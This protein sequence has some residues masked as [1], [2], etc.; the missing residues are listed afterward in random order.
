VVVSLVEGLGGR[1]DDE[2][3][4]DAGEDCAADDVE[5][6]K[7]PVLGLQLLVGGV[8]LDEGEPPGANVVPKVAVATRTA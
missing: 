4:D 1:D 2:Q 8:G 6:G 7:M 5:A 3:A